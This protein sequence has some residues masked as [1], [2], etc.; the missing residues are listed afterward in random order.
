MFRKLAAAALLLLTACERHDQAPVVTN[1][2]AAAGAAIAPILTSAD[3][4]DIHSYAKPLEAR[5][6][7][8]ALDLAVDFDAKRVGGTATLDIERKLTQTTNPLWKRR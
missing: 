5:V 4:M 7:H 1:E 6:H 3:A 8:V 2:Q